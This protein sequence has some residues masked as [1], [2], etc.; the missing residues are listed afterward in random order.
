MKRFLHSKIM[1]VVIS[2]LLIVVSCKKS[3]SPVEP[4]PTGPTVT[5]KIKNVQDQKDSLLTTLLT[6]KDTTTALNS[7][8]QAYLQDTSV[9]TGYVSSQGVSIVYKNGS[10]GGI[11]ISPQDGL[12][13]QYKMSK[14]NVLLIPPKV[15]NYTPTSKKTIFIN[16]HY[17]DRVAYANAILNS[18]NV[19]FPRIGYDP[20]QKFLDDAATVDVMT[21]LAG[22]GIVHIYSHGWAWPTSKSISEVYVM[23]GETVNA[24]TSKKYENEILNGNIPLV[25]IHKGANKY[26]LSPSFFASKN[27]FAKD[28]TIVYGGFC[29]AFLGSWPNAIT[30]T[31]H[32]GAYTGFTWAVYTNYNAGWA[33]SLFDTLSNNAV[34]TPK[35][36][37][38]WFTQTPTIGKQYYN[39]QDK[40]N[41]KIEYVGHSDLTLWQ[42]AVID[43]L[44][45]NRGASGESVIIY[46][47]G[48]GAAQ[49]N[50]KVTFNNITASVT[51]WTD[52]KIKVTVPSGNFEGY[53]VVTVN[54]IESNKVLFGNSANASINFNYSWVDNH[55]S[56][57][58]RFYI[59][60]N[61]S[62]S[63]EGTGGNKA[64]E[65]V[66][67]KYQK[68]LVNANFSDY[69][70]FKITF[71]SSFSVSPTKIDTTYADGSYDVFTFEGNQGMKWFTSTFNPYTFQATSGGTFENPNC[72][73]TISIYGYMDTKLERYDK[74][75]KLYDTITGPSTW[76]LGSISFDKK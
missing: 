8:L 76:V 65:V 49:G 66:D 13:I 37:D 39:N 38:Y 74:E 3:D 71:N 18:Y 57:W 15:T 42:N 10:R 19:I 55:T 26:F 22:Y 53:V 43:S 59:T 64:V 9:A 14:S 34:K 45:P 17:S 35:S 1:L 28:S 40:L 63:V 20:P 12:P 68:G 62:G 73:G 5:D 72:F 69:G 44:S 11:L 58:P 70:P 50:S 29:F 61:L 36:L 4:T 51:S 23:T 25:K 33:I 7:L 32:A 75:K 60:F 54:N 56:Y 47:K 30:G 67:N 48:F 24:A 6:T 21:N 46:G 2:F 52:K 16:P 31:A 27:N 41:V